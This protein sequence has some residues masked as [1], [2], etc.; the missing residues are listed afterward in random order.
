MKYRRLLRMTLKLGLVCGLS[1]FV[2]SYLWAYGF[3]TE[4]MTQEVL[5]MRGV[6]ALWKGFY[7]GGLYFSFPMWLAFETFRRPEQRL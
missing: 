4:G 1:G 5:T 6:E 7:Y 2:A 3:S